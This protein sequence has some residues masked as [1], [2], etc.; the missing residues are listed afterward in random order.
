MFDY[1]TYA[2]HNGRNPSHVPGG[3]TRQQRRH[4]ARLAAKILQHEE[5]ARVRAAHKRTQR[6]S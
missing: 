5:S 2:D 4:Q 1:K 3:Y 6:A